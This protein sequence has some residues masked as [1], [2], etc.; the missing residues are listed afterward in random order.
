MHKDKYLEIY[1]S[2]IQSVISWEGLKPQACNLPQIYSY[3]ANT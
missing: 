2:D 1:N 3:L